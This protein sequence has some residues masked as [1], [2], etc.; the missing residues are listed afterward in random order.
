MKQL[1]KFTSIILILSLL[2]AAAGCSSSKKGQC[3]CP[4]KTGFIGY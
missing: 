1:F 2:L 4:Q 3:G